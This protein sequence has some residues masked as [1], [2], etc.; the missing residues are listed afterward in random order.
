MGLLMKYN[1]S[2]RTVSPEEMPI[3]M[4][5]GLKAEMAGA[6]TSGSNPKKIIFPL[7]H[8][9]QLQ[10]RKTLPYYQYYFF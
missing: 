7:S 3:L 1:P 9:D 10:Y 5:E 6:L 8:R 4:G 2:K